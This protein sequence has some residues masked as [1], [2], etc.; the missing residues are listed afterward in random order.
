MISGKT[1]SRV[2][3]QRGF[4]L[5]ELVLVLA[6][7]SAMV[8]IAVPYATKSNEALKIKQQALNIAQAVQYALDLSI[9]TKRPTRIV[10]DTRNKSYVLQLA[11]QR[12]NR[13][14]EPLEGFYGATRYIAKSIQVSDITGFDVDGNGYNLVFDPHQKWPTAAVSLTDK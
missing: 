3:T 7:V 13:N 5:L 6:I 11:A 10:I 2:L 8:T 14:F 4:T 1:N 9:N 12:N